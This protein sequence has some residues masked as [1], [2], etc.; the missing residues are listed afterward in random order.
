M[1]K[2]K[3]SLTL[4]GKTLL[5]RAVE[6]LLHCTWPVVVVARGGDQQMP[7]LPPKQK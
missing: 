7:P 4:G 1:G 5:G 6:T 2:P 3:E